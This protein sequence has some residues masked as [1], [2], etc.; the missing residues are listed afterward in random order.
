MATLAVVPQRRRSARLPRVGV[1]GAPAV[2]VSVW[3][4]CVGPTRVAMQP[5]MNGSRPGGEPIQPIE[6]STAVREIDHDEAIALAS[7]E[8]PPAQGT[9]TLASLLQRLF[10]G[11][12]APFMFGVFGV[13]DEDL[14]HGRLPTIAGRQQ[15]ARPAAARKNPRCAAFLCGPVTRPR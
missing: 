3:F 15:G 11:S 7:E 9:I 8:T 4:G 1:L 14:P 5:P 2:M 10:A 12:H 6:E 13:F